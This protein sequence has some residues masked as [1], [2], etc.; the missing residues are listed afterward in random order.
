V[1]APSGG[2]PQN[3]RV[4][5]RLLAVSVVL[6]LG[7]CGGG[8][9]K[10]AAPSASAAAKEAPGVMVFERPRPASLEL[11]YIRILNTGEANLRW[12]KTGVHLEMIGATA[13]FDPQ[14]G[15][16]APGALK[17]GQEYVVAYVG[18]APAGF[19][20]RR[21]TDAVVKVG[22]AAR[23]VPPF[24][25]RAF[26]VVAAPRDAVVRLELTDTERMQW[27]DLRTAEVGNVIPGYDPR[28]RD[29][30]SLECDL[31][32]ADKTVDGSA[33]VLMTTA[34]LEPW[35]DGRGWA[36]RGRIWFDLKVQLW[37]SDNGVAF[38]FDGP[39]SVT[40]TGPEGPI[41]VT[42]PLAFGGPSQQDPHMGQWELVADVPVGI[43]VAQLAFQPKGT[44][45]VKG[46]PVPKWTASC[47]TK[48]D[49]FSFQ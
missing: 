3:R 38:A 47:E 20:A 39:G 26:I 22:G 41:P 33:L 15:T 24:E 27:V 11:P 5:K 4:P 44:I 40:I 49:A 1:T 7:A 48:A 35:V 16:P 36:A 12:P 32:S 28:K 6:L 43:T 21:F 34:T 18:S 25:S 19:T 29:G 2:G 23:A 13:A 45:A 31:A 8:H 9:P 46:T 42:F 30:A 37:Y 14:L 10:A 17:D